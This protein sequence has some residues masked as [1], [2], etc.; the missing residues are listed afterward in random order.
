MIDSGEIAADAP[1]ELLEGRIVEK[2]TKNPPH[3][4]AMKRIT[5]LLHKVLP[6][7]WHPQFQDSILLEDS[8]PEPDGAI[9]RGDADDYDELAKAEDIGLLIEV[10]DTTLNE[11][12]RKAAMYARG[13]I[14]RY[15][16]LNLRSE[17]VEVYDQLN[18]AG[19]EP[20]YD[21]VETYHRGDLVNLIL[22]DQTVAE[23]PVDDLL[24][25]A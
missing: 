10:A 22:D 8:M 18:D 9:I 21:L 20:S 3:I 11:D 4:K 17:C 19:P 12:R 15:W 24:P 5:R 13:R 25:P 16:I 6:D 23:L 14:P 7:S 2:V 1:V